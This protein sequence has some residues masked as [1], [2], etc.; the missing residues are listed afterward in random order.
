MEYSEF[1]DMMASQM[2]EPMTAEDLKYYFNKFDRDGNGYITSDEVALVINTYG[3][4]SYSKQEIDD[5]IK[6]ADL[7]SDGQISY[8]GTIFLRGFNLTKR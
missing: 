6:D 3:G 1:E 5:M 8:D 4:R 2:G 7:D